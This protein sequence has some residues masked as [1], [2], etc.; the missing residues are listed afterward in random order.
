MITCILALIE[1][2]ILVLENGFFSKQKRAP[3]GSSFIV[4][5]KTIFKYKI[6]M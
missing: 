6:V 5:E 2:K 3:N 4:I 1:M